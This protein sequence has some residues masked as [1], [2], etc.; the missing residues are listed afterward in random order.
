MAA[1]CF[2]MG[3]SVFNRP[4]IIFFGLESKEKC[5][6][7]LIFGHTVEYFDLVISTEKSSIKPGERKEVVGNWKA[8]VAPG[9]YTAKAKVTYDNKIV[10]IE[11]NFS[12]GEKVLELKSVEVKSFILGGIAKFEM[13]VDNKWNE[14]IKNVYSQT[15][16]FDS[17]R[18]LIVDF[19]SPTYDIV[20]L[21]NQTFFSYWDTE[22]I[23]PGLY[24]ASIYLR[25]DEKFSK[26]NVQFEVNEDSIRTLG[27]GYVISEGKSGGNTKTSILIIV[28][29]LL[30]LLNLLWFVLFRKKMKK[31][32]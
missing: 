16:V 11:K 19:K 1:M 10:Q 5:S 17:K 31:A 6:H 27:L 24:D 13:A 14:E 18:N 23:K 3:H 4:R 20:A 2:Y 28:I 26:K 30:V 8:D 12:I 29:I 21:S 22:N 32:K 25:Y 9:M 15:N 7:Y